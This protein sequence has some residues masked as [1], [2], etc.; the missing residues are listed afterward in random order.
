LGHGQRQ[1]GQPLRQPPTQI[2]HVELHRFILQRGKSMEK[3]QIC[4]D[5]L[6]CGMSWGKNGDWRLEIGD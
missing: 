3:V 4:H 5:L 2:V 1:E 6:Y